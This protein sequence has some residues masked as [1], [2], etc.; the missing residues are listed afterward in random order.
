MDDLF[1]EIESLAPGGDAVGR[2]QG[3]GDSDGR[4]TFVPLAAPGERVRTRIVRAQGKVAWGE[5]LEI[6]R[7]GPDRVPPP[8]PLFGACGGCQ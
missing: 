3:G 5:L 6:Q 7:A 4:V 8:C 2:Q 1:V